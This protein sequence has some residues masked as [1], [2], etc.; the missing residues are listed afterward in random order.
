MK[1]WVITLILVVAVVA[2]LGYVL[3]LAGVGQDKVTLGGKT[4]IVT[5]ARTDAERQQGLS[6]TKSLPPD[7][8]MLFVFPEASIEG[9][10][11]WMKDMNYPIDI[12]W[13]DGGRKV[14]YTVNDAEPSGYNKAFPLAST[15]YTP[16]APARYVIELP[17]GTISKTGVNEDTV[18]TLPSGL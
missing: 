1:R 12:V 13:L 2:G 3:G 4:Y 8:A 14:V 16:S 5:I 6:G 9:T 7:H 11:I 10:R 15:I 17:N 18:A